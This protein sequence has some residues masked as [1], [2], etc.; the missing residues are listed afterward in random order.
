M[1]AGELKGLKSDSPVDWAGFLK[2]VGRTIRPD[3]TL[4]IIASAKPTDAAVGGHRKR[5]LSAVAHGNGTPDAPT[6][7]RPGTAPSPASRGMR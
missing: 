4:E 5:K 2:F 3:R 7:L 6:Y 1:L